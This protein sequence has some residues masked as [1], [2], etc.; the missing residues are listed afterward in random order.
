MLV[1]AF[2][3]PEVGLPGDDPPALSGEWSR[4]YEGAARQRCLKRLAGQLFRRFVDPF[5]A[6]ELVKVWND[7]R[8]V[9]PLSADDVKA[10]IDAAA[11]RQLEREIV[12]AAV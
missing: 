2:E 4:T 3:A 5:L 8:C 10:I 11:K 12:R 1:R 7:S 6:A 9:P